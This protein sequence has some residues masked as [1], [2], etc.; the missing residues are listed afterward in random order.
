MAVE[1]FID[2]E[3]L[4]YADIPVTR[5]LPVSSAPEEEQRAKRQREAF[6]RLQARAADDPVVADILTMLDARLTG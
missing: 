5:V 3:H 6:L 4:R 1:R 2:L